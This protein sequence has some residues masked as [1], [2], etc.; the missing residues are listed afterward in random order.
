MQ[1]FPPIDDLNFL[2]GKEIS[3][4]VFETCG[5]HF[6]WWD[7]GEIHAM[8]DFSHIDPEGKYHQFGE[9]LLDPPSLLHRLIQRKVVALE[10]NEDSMVMKFDDGQS[11]IFHA[12][13]GRGENRLIQ[14]GRT[15][16]DDWIVW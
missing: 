15:L 12:V 3:N 4:I 1:L 14:F 9:G 7:G 16:E 8:R 2:L 5:V 13:A 6:I 10:V 11:L